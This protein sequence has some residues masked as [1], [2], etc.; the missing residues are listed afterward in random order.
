MLFLGKVALQALNVLLNANVLKRE[1][2]QH[3]K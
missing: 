1:G 2:K 3:E